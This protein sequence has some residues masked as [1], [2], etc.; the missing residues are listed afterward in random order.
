MTVRRKVDGKIIHDVSGE[1][2]GEEEERKKKEETVRK[3]QSVQKKEKKKLD[4]PS[5]TSSLPL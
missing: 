3:L 5:T 2:E 1:G 4:A